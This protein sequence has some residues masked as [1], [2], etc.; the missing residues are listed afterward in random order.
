MNASPKLSKHG[1]T[2]RSEPIVRFGRIVSHPQELCREACRDTEGNAYTVI[3]WRPLPG[4]NLTEYTLDDGR[5][6]K[7]VDDCRFEIVDSGVL[8]SYPAKGHK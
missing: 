2:V 8:V 4:L 6:V 3:V 5:P 1:S 7:F